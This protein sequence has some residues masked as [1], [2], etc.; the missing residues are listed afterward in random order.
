MDGELAEIGYNPFT[1][2]LLS[3]C[4]CGAGT[5]EEVG[6]Q[7]AF[8]GRGADDAL[9]QG[10]GFLSRVFCV[11]KSLGVHGW[12]IIPERLQGNTFLLV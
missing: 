4:R 11:F 12:Y 3:H 7:V 6:C 2:Q 1:A 8:I 10:F 5:D 9:E